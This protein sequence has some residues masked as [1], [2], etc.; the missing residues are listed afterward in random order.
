[1]VF[2]TMSPVT[3]KMRMGTIHCRVRAVTYQTA[4]AKYELTTSDI[5]RNAGVDQSR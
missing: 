1:L 4:D 5:A 2:R 3:V